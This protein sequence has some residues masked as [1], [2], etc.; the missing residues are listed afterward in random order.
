MSQRA[1]E[2][3]QKLKSL[4]TPVSATKTSSSVS[5]GSKRKATDTAI[6]A[7]PNGEPPAKVCGHFE[8]IFLDII[9]FKCE[10]IPYF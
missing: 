10:P 8:L 3:A 5:I 2:Q 1:E 6:D 9:N 7:S 4:L